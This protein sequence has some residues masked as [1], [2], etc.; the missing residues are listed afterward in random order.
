MPKKQKQK[1]TKGKA[2]TNSKT[3]AKSASPTP[4]GLDPQADELCVEMSVF[5]NQSLIAIKENDE[6][7]AEVKLTIGCSLT[8]I[9]DKYGVGV[10]LYFDSIKCLICL[11]LLIF[12][13]RKKKTKLSIHL[14]I[15]SFLYSSCEFCLSHLQIRLQRA[16]NKRI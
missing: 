6:Q 16:V 10:S 4:M 11:N 14:F 3:K 2:G 1:Q 13:P 15:H 12:V 5:S 7:A 9:N 8:D